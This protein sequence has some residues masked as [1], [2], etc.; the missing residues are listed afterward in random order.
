VITDEWVGKSKNI[1]AS[2]IDPTALDG[3]ISAT[4][5]E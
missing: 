2:L 1:R 3:V 4:R 5:R